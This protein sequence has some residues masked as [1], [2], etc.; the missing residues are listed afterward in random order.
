VEAS[1]RGV[2]LGQGTHGR[3]RILSSYADNHSGLPEAR[4]CACKRRCSVVGCHRR[5]P[6]RISWGLGSSAINKRHARRV[7]WVGC[8]WQATPDL[9]PV[10]SVHPRAN[11]VQCTSSSHL[12]PFL[13]LAALVIFDHPPLF[14]SVPFRV[15]LLGSRLYQYVPSTFPLSWPPLR[16]SPTRWPRHRWLSTCHLS[17]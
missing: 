2:Q 4:P 10:A 8:T 15:D 13:T 16:P 6:V 12:P 17:T 7:T 14:R 5:G 3:P 1:P 9:V 11:A